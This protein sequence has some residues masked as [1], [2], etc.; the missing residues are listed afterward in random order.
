MGL[1]SPPRAAPGQRNFNR[2]RLGVPASLVLVHETKRCLIDDISTSG[3]RLRIDYAVL[4]GATTQLVFHELRAY[5]TVMWCHGGECGLRFETPL[6]LE[7][8]QGMLWITENRA[9]YDRICNEAHALAWSE[10]VGD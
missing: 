5:A 7:D 4:P 2:L 3:V 1:H 9:V 6:D 10:G 8:M